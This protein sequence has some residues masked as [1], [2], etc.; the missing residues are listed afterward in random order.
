MED[1]LASGDDLEIA[2]YRVVKLKIEDFPEH[3]RDDPQEVSTAL[4]A[5][6][7][8]ARDVHPELTSGSE[9]HDLVLLRLIPKEKTRRYL[10]ELK[11]E[12]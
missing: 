2:L 8:F 12:G 9:I 6:Q 4:A 5:V 10:E 1:F 7:Y 3:L 11:S